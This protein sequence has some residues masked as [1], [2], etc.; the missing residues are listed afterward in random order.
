MVTNS[1]ILSEFVLRHTLSS[2]RVVR[3][4][5]SWC[6]APFC[7]FGCNRE[8]IYYYYHAFLHVPLQCRLYQ[9]CEFFLEILVL[10]FVLTSRRKC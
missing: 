10:H 5:E 3:V 6:L 4:R 1:D 7:T 9:R 8:L 2:D